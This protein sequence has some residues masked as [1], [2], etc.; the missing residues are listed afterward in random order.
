MFT[1]GGT[2]ADNLAVKGL[3]WSRQ[4]TG[5]RP[6]ILASSV[7]HHAV[8]DPVRWLA[9][10]QGADVVWLDVDAVGRVDPQQVHDEISRDPESVALV[11]VMWANNEVGTVQPVG[12]VRGR[13]IR[14]R[15]AHALRRGAGGRTPP[16]GFP[17]LRA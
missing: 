6:K 1:G 4:Q 3:Y 16:A 11:T 8:L 15:C 12:R 14:L 13:G 17:R 10:T 9:E 5:P 7:E 2:E